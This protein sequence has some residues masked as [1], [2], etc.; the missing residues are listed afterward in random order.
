MVHG[1]EYVIS[2]CTKS[3]DINFNIQGG[4]ENPHYYVALGPHP[5]DPDRHMVAGVTHH[6]R[7]GLLGPAEPLPATGQGSA[8]GLTG[9]V[10]L[11]PT[12]AHVQHISR[13]DPRQNHVQ[14]NVG[15][16][17]ISDYHNCA[18]CWSSVV[19]LSLISQSKSSATT[20]QSCTRCPWACE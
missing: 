8:H 5:T 17:W 3:V 15:H 9:D 19:L 16:Q 18:L 10:L 13:T 14:G 20:K 6:G 1:L 12:S 4:A 11:T 7:V 2:I